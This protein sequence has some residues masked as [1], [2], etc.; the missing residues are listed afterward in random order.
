MSELPKPA[1]AARHETDNARLDAM[2]E[3]VRSLRE[4]LELVKDKSIMIEEFARSQICEEEKHTGEVEKMIG[5]P[6]LVA[7]GE[8]CC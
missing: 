1:P 7:S 3:E 2:S 6:G 4:L 5:N 8:S